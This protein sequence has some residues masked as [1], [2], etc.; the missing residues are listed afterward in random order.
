VLPGQ[1]RRQKG[2]T[3]FGTLHDHKGSSQGYQQ[4]VATGEV[5]RQ[6]PASRGKFA[7]EQSLGTHLGLQGKV[8]TGI[9]PFQGGA[10]Y[11][12]RN[13]SPLKTTSMDG[14]VNSLG[15]TADDGPTRFCQNGTQLACHEQAML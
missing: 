2:A 11:T 6:N 7:D 4:P 8:V 15:Q 3:A 1:L 9:H 14:T 10:E 13:P 5:A 12:D